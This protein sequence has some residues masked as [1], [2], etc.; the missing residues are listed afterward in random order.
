VR[1]AETPFRLVKLFLTPFAFPG[2]A[3]SELL[4]APATAEL[5]VPRLPC[6]MTEKTFVGCAWASSMRLAG[7]SA[8]AA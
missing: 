7:T 3:A 5:F 2:R 4:T 1:A 8:R 6:T